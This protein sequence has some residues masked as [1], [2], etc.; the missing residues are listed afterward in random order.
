MENLTSEKVNLNTD[1]IQFDSAIST[2]LQD[3]TKKSKD[4]TIVNTHYQKKFTDKHLDTTKRII[5][6]EAY[7]ELYGDKLPEDME[8][9]GFRIIPMNTIDRVNIR[10]FKS[11]SSSLVKTLP[12][13]PE[14]KT[15]L[16]TLPP[17]P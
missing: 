12:L 16:K 13:L 5:S 14:V 17:L 3:L 2:G 6:L 9:I 7:P 15:S 8:F 10:V 4:E 1:K 11:S